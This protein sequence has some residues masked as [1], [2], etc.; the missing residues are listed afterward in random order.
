MYL[1]QARD[2]S[3][4]FEYDHK[5]A[6]L[7]Q[8]I[9]KKSE[10]GDGVKAFCDC[11][12]KLN[13]YSYWFMLGTLWVDSVDGASIALWKS[14]FSSKRKK[15]DSCLMKPSEL[16]FLKKMADEVTVYRAK[17]KGEEDWLAYTLDPNFAA[18]MAFSRAVDV[19]HEYKV[20]KSDIT[21]VFLRRGEAE[22][23]VLDNRKPEFIRTVGVK[24]IGNEDE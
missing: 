5:N 21:A 1:A 7:I 2:I 17:R 10:S 19:I 14:L 3:P 9:L 23:L 20:K 22:V 4:D 16:R 12:S 15:R 8:K 6:K 13:D 11:K 18:K 24:V